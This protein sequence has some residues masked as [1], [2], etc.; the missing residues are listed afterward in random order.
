[1][2]ARQD[3]F[4][5]SVKSILC[6]GPIIIGLLI[7]FS[8]SANA[9]Y[10]YEAS[11][12]FN[13]SSS[14]SRGAINLAEC[15]LTYDSYMLPVNPLNPGY[16]F[17]YNWYYDCDNVSSGSS[18]KQKRI[19]LQ[20]KYF[21]KPVKTS[22]NQ[23]LAEAAFF[24]KSSWGEVGI[25]LA[26]PDSGKN[27]KTLELG[28]R[29]VLPNGVFAST[30]IRNGDIDDVALELGQYIDTETTVSGRYKVSDYIAQLEG[31]FKKVSRFSGTNFI[32]LDA[33]IGLLDGSRDE[34]AYRLAAEADYYFDSHWSA[35]GQ[36]GFTF[37]DFKEQLIG[38]QSR[39]FF[40]E[41]LSVTG[42]LQ[43]ENK[44]KTN[45]IEIEFTGRW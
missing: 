24:N 36:F 22:V 39:Y 38:I 9:D 28:G 29:Y 30:L 18:Q 2:P 1:M 33:S 23:P 13:H 6:S 17:G 37:G 40:N 26:D 10:R 11:A 45:L 8:S 21:L 32:G 4:V 25:S 19:S 35:G 5:R 43:R 12:S 20:G 41:Q 31:H 27:I 34:T 16:G 7:P 42:V 15:N 14:K 3:T 44:S